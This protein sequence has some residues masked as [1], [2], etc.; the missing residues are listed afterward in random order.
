MR[1]IKKLDLHSITYTAFEETDFDM[2]LSAIATIP[3]IG[4]ERNPLRNYAIWRDP[5]DLREKTEVPV[6]EV[7]FD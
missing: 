4:D 7:L 2:G 5:R 6:K 3:L 1:V